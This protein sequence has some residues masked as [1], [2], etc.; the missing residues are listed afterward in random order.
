MRPPANILLLILAAAAVL[1]PV[2]AFA[3]STTFTFAGFD[4]DANGVTRAA[5]A[6][7]V[8][9]NTQLDLRLT[10]LAPTAAKDP[11]EILTAV[12]FDLLPGTP[13]LTPGSALVAPGSMINTNNVLTAGSVV[14][15][16]WAY[17]YGTLAYNG[18]QGVS[19]S[20]FGLFGNANFPGPNIQGPVAVDGAQ[21]GII[22]PYG[23]ATDQNGD[24]VSPLRSTD[25]KPQS[26]IQNAVDFT[27]TD[28]NLRVQSQQCRLSVRDKPPG[29]SF[30][31]SWRRRAPGGPRAVDRDRSFCRP[32]RVGR[33]R[34]QAHPCLSA[35]LCCRACCMTAWGA[36]I[37]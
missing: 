25:P 36:V 17:A 13:A 37:G 23:I 10:N 12:F 26:F 33:L 35:R 32:V 30:C 16:E 18:D 14:G 28:G 7:F 29:S 15:G 9:N 2:Q 27:L 3:V 24:P 5:S 1:V 8:I 11:T 6:K 22:G 20:G 4:V 19:S 31:P 34:P 21:Y